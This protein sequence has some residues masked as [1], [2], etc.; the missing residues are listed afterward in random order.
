MIK[1]ITHIPIYVLVLCAVMYGPTLLHKQLPSIYKAQAA[2]REVYGVVERVTD[3][4]TIVVITDN[5]TKLKI[6][7]YGID[8]PETSH[9]P[10]PGQPMARRQVWRC[11][12]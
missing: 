2:S 7:F 5:G 12:G 4:D 8:A 3:G 10:K 9:G 6:R 11:K 1:P